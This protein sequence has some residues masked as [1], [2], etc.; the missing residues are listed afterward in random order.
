MWIVHPKVG[1]LER[2]L[3]GCHRTRARFV[4]NSNYTVVKS[5]AT[6]EV[7]L[8]MY[9]DPKGRDF[10]LLLNLLAETAGLAHSFRILTV[11]DKH[12][13]RLWRATD[14][15]VGMKR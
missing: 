6:P 12:F 2:I 14:V 13:Q 3:T 8:D 1:K 15:K 4:D 9:F 5:D 7:R 10:K 11:F